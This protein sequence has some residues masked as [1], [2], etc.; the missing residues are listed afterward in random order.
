MTSRR[1]KDMTQVIS[2]HIFQDMAPVYTVEKN[3]FHDLIKT[4]EICDAEPSAKSSCQ[5][6]EEELSNELFLF[7]G[8]Y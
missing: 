1:L 3:G 7:H 4:P 6:V 5:N 8:I 2:M